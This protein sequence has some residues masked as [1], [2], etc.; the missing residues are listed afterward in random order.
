MAKSSATKRQRNNIRIAKKIEK[1][2]R[3]WDYALAQLEK[4][5]KKIDKKFSVM[6]D[7]YDAQLAKLSKKL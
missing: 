6:I 1:A 2:Y 3:Q 7:R 5:Q 4:K